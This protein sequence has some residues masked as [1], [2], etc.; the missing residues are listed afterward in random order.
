[1]S[2]AVSYD[3]ELR[4]LVELATAQGWSLL[5]QNGKLRW[6]P[7]AGSSGSV[8]FTPTRV[9]Q[10]RALKNVQRTLAR[11]GVELDSLKPAA[12]KLSG[13]QTRS[14]VRAVNVA[15]GTGD[16]LDTMPVGHKMVVLHGVPLVDAIST[17]VA[18]YTE[19][20]MVDLQDLV[21]SARRELQDE[22]ADHERTR[23]A[24]ARCKDMLSQQG[25]TITQCNEQVAALTSRADKASKRLKTMRDALSPESDD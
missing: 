17:A 24:M 14:V 7:P 18:L 9:G 23:L 13:E 8:V 20:I 2:S 5:E 1:M 16:T 11:A 25:R 15:L 12:G 6:C 3:K 22:R 4:P 10:G 21:D 19:S